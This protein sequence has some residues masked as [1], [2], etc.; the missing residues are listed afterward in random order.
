MQMRGE[1]LFD[2]TKFLCKHKC[3]TPSLT[4]CSIPELAAAINQP[5]DVIFID[6][7]KSS[8]PNYLSLILS[9]SGSSTPIRLLRPGGIIIADNILRRGLVA[10][11]ST[12]NPFSTPSELSTEKGGRG[13]ELIALDKFNKE[14]VENERIESFLLP[15]FDGLGMGRLRD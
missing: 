10:D 11:K 3:K 6:A 8:Y 5:Y 7:D 13:E 4:T 9:L 15:L 1:F 14:L 2:P 12:S